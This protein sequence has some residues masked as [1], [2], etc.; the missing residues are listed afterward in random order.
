MRLLQSLLVFVDKSNRWSPF[1]YLG[2]GVDRE[3]LGRILGN[4]CLGMADSARIGRSSSNLF[5][6]ETEP[7]MQKTCILTYGLGQWCFYPFL[8]DSEMG[9][10][11]TKSVSRA[12]LPEKLLLELH[13]SSTGICSYRTQRQQTDILIHCRGSEIRAGG[14]Q[15]FTQVSPPSPPSTELSFRDCG[16]VHGVWLGSASL[17]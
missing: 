10:R 12:L 4:H 16:S 17:G 5:S 15:W 1:L 14:G 3:P 7:P 9:W 11:H 2:V 13:K 6:K 8:L